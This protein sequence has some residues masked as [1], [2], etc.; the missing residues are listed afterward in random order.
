MEKEQF[1][2]LLA[3]YK[4]A[5]ERFVFFKTP[6]KAD[7]EDVIQEVFL[8]AYKNRDSL[9]DE[10]K[11][12]AWLLSIASNRVKDFYRKRAA[13]AELLY[14]DMTEAMP[15]QSRFGLTVEE[16]VRETISEMGDMDKRMLVWFYLLGL[17]CEEIAARLQIPLGTVK[18]RLHTAR[19]RFAN[20]YPYRPKSKGEKIMSQTKMPSI[21]PEVKIEVSKEAPFA[22]KWEEIMGWF[23]IPRLGESCEWAMYDYPERKMTETFTCKVVGRAAVHGVEGVEIVTTERTFRNARGSEVSDG[24]ERN[25]IAQLTDT[26]S[27]YLAETHMEDGVKRTYTFLDGDDF[28]KNWGYGADNCGNEINIYAKG[29]I[30]KN[31]ASISAAPLDMELM[32]VAGRYT[33][34]VGAKAYDTI[35]L[36]DIGTYNEGVLSESYIDKDGRTVLWRRFNRDDWKLARYGKRWSEALPDNERVTVNGETYVHWYS[37]L[38]DYI[39]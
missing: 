17:S 21:M 35:L 38:T 1:E 31:G 10:A 27:R 18:S 26:H 20:Q 36:L 33:V 34:T 29:R 11:G 5:V 23:I 28:M 16:R 15:V 22:V 2:A 9:R 39:V 25:F 3:V 30:T 32:D 7:G 8:S 19:K 6:T 12:K 4:G 14:E 13:H 24:T 37:C